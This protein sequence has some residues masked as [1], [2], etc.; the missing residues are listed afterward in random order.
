[1]IL[2]EKGQIR[3]RAERELARGVCQGQLLGELGNGAANNGF[4]VDG[5]AQLLN[6]PR[7]VKT[8]MPEDLG[9]SRMEGGGQTKAQGR[10][11]ECGGDSA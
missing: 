5:D 3:V 4:E 7:R 10:T 2:A 8:L 9:G 6:F 11:A 1:M